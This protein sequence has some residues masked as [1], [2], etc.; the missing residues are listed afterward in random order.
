[1]AK[2]ASVWVGF[3]ACAADP[4]LTSHPQ[5]FVILFGKDQADR[6]QESRDVSEIGPLKPK[7]ER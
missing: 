4:P 3:R 2:T 1:M 5:I 6:I 7:F